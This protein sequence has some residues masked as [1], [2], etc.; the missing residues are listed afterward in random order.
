ML[1][2]R[3]REGHPDPTTLPLHPILAAAY[4]VVF[5]F[6]VN[7]DEQVT[8]GPLWLPLLLSVGITGAVLAV[9]GLLLRDWQRAGLVT[10]VL[11][12][13]FFGY[14]DAWNAGS[15]IIHKQLP[16]IN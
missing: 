13:G 14:G 12:I 6:A 8:T 16:L 3:G 15:Q 9:L 7:A 4:P 11:V 10:T 5:L 1:T 2:L